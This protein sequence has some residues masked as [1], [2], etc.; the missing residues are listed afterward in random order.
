MTTLAAVLEVASTSTPG[1]SYRVW[2][3]EAGPIFCDC[4]AHKFHRGKPAGERPDCKHM[5]TVRG[6]TTLAQAR[7]I[8][9]GQTLATVALAGDAQVRFLELQEETTEGTWV[10]VTDL[11]RFTNL[12]LE[13]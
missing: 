8:A 2:V 10:P 4:P 3:G 5:R 6:S 13:V 1:K 11:R 9:A 7:A 12:D